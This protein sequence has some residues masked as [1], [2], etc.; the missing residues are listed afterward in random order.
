MLRIT[1]TMTSHAPLRITATMMTT[2]TM[3]GCRKSCPG[4][5]RTGEAEVGQFEVVCRDGTDLRLW[6]GC[7][8]IVAELVAVL[9]RDRGRA[10][11]EESALWS[12]VPVIQRLPGSSHLP[13]HLLWSR[14]GLRRPLQAASAVQLPGVNISAV[15]NSLSV[16][17]RPRR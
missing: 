17:G 7:G 4:C 16:A 10:V 14:A 6:C 2:T 12:A 15:N 9:W 1:A 11:T 8:G 5:P 3:T 13:G